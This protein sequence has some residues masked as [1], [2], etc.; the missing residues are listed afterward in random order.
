M[1][2]DVYFPRVNGVSTSIRTFSREFRRL[3]H[4]VTLIA[5]RYPVDEE[6]DIEII[7]IASRYLPM[8]PEDRMMK[9]KAVKQLLPEL[10][11]RQFDII[12]IHTP[13]I[14]HYLGLWLSRKLSIPVVET[15]HTYFEEYLDLYLRWLP[16]KLL[17]YIA[18]RF[19]R[20]QCNEIS[21]VIVPTRPMLD[22]LESYGVTGKMAIIP[23][24]I[25]SKIFSDGQGQ[26]FREKYD[27]AASREV[28]LYVGR[29]AHEKN[30][31]FLIR[32]LAEVVIKRPQIL[33][34]IAGEGPA[35]QAL[36]H[37][38]HSAGLSH[39]VLFLG[40]L[41]R[42]H[43]LANCYAAADIF[44]FASNTETQ[45][46]VLLEAMQT[47][48]PVVTTAVMGTA[49]IMRDGRG[50]LIAR[51]DVDDF[52][53]KIDAVLSDESLRKRLMREAHEKAQA[54]DAGVMAE[55]MLE[56]YELERSTHSSQDQRQ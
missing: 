18:R 11:G 4:E 19:S 38:V 24:G 23:T 37:Q 35:R 54:W 6:D 39:Q 36:I 51:E 27:I 5:P 13:F 1:I 47:G 34:V 17:R 32:V 44:V 48:T 21:T 15:Y 2:S 16:R 50:G 49:E 10:L 52:V 12:H 45:G 29:V 42:K 33:L 26:W 31:D 46:L 20:S 56:L 41:S 3:G 53:E 22:V 30:I 9:S 8:D 28:L 25:P 55:R 40:Y 7:R 43:E 14:A